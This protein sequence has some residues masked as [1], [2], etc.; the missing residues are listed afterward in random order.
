MPSHYLEILA[1][2]RPFPI[3]IGDDA[4]I[5]FSGNYRATAYSPVADWPIDIVKILVA[6]GVAQ[7]NVDIFIGAVATLPAGDSAYTTIFETGGMAPEETHNGGKYERMTAQLLTRASNYATAR[8]K[9]FAIYNAL[10]GIRNR[11]VT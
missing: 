7:A 4:R 11:D 8:D 5:M 10:D 3:D 1:I 6:A 9:A 2:Q